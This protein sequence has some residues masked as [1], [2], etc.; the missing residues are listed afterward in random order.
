MK[1][2]FVTSI[3]VCSFLIGYSYK[4]KLKEKLNL[5]FYLRDFFKNIKSNINLFKCNIIEIIDNYILNKNA[6]YNEIFI[7]NEQIY[8][9]SSKNLKKYLMNEQEILILEK[10]FNDIGSNDYEYELKK[11]NDFE[12]YL[13]D[14]I[15]ESEKI[16]KNKGELFFKIALSVGAVFAILIWWDYG[17]INFI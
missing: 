11:F 5:Y 6:K 4:Y 9:I 2:I 10:F 1:V 8:K 16:V 17:R 7:K 3:M 14:K 13:D 15:I 12:K